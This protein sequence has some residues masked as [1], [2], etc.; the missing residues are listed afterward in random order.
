MRMNTQTMQVQLGIT[1]LILSESRSSHPETSNQLASESSWPTSLT[2]LGLQQ[3]TSM[4]TTIAFLLEISGMRPEYIEN[5]VPKNA[6]LLAGFKSC[7]KTELFLA[8]YD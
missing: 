6:E 7:L 1:E 2:N 3:W 5:R 8:A 4:R